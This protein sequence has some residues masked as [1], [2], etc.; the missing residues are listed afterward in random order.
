[1]AD[2]AWTLADLAWTQN[3]WFLIWPAVKPSLCVSVLQAHATCYKSLPAEC[4]FG[5][6]REIMLPP[7]CL[8]IPR[9]DVPMET[10]L[11][12]NRKPSQFWCVVRFFPFICLLVW[13]W[14]VASKSAGTEN[15]CTVLY[16]LIKISILVKCLCAFILFENTSSHH[17]FRSLLKLKWK[18]LDIAIPRLRS[19]I[20][21]QALVYDKFPA[22][23]A[24]T[25]YAVGLP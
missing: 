19:E 17:C 6:L 5:S 15:F 3:S 22:T 2:L 13:H 14:F 1:M 7:S 21:L 23:A 20:E 16:C 24:I 12:I 10:I 9:M 25:G 11:G 4:K 18:H 8:T